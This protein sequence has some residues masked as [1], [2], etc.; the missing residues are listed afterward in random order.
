MGVVAWKPEALASV[1]GAPA[2][3]RG[4][5]IRILRV[6]AREVGVARPIEVVR[7]GASLDGTLVL[8]FR[9]DGR[10]FRY[11]EWGREITVTDVWPS[12]AGPVRPW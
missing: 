7:V 12:G 3:V 9:V 2:G 8:E 1:R 5:A 11:V 4:E 6:A 10:R